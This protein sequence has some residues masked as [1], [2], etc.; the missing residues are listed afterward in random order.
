VREI[1][2]T[3]TAYEHRG[4]V[5]LV[6][7]ANTGET[8]G[9]DLDAVEA[10]IFAFRLAL[11]LYKRPPKP[12]VHMPYINPVHPPEAPAFA[13]TGLPRIGGLVLLLFP[14]EGLRLLLSDG[15]YGDVFPRV[16]G[17]LLTG[18]GI[19]ILGIIRARAEALYPETLIVRAFF[20]VCLGA[21]FLMTRDPLFLVLIAIVAFGFVLTG[22]TYLTEKK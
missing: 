13:A 6:I 15:D 10:E 8:L 20:L 12:P 22:L 2:G 7:V 16:A 19:A 3:I 14:K 1:V 4:R 9:I 18:L 5:R 11:S 17:M 21:F